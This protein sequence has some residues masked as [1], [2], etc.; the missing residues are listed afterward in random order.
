M[1]SPRAPSV[2]LP[3]GNKEK[4]LGCRVA[5][6]PA[7]RQANTAPGGAP[8][9]AIPG[10]AAEGER[11]TSAGSPPWRTKRPGAHCTEVAPHHLHPICASTRHTGWGS[12]QDGDSVLELSPDLGHSQGC[13]SVWREGSVQH[14]DLS[15][16]SGLQPIT[17]A[18]SPFPNLQRVGPWLGCSS[19]QCRVQLSPLPA[20]QGAWEGG[21]QPPPCCGLAPTSSFICTSSRAVATRSRCLLADSTWLQ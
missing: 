17:P 19:K 1:R 11:D 10:A 13:S 12:V 5:G 14:Q 9:S 16:A 2:N 7:G 8:D 3:R 6:D 4:V 15:L 21:T 20:P 18:V